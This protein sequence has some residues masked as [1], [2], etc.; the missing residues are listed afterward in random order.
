M[1]RSP[2]EDTGRVGESSASSGVEERGQEEGAESGQ[3]VDREMQMAQ[4]ASLARLPL[5]WLLGFPLF[6]C[7]MASQINTCLCSSTQS[8]FISSLF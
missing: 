5:P 2:A 7:I 4:I 8:K 3:R 6:M 1:V